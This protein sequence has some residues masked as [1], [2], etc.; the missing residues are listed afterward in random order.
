MARWGRRSVLAALAGL[1]A[2]ALGAAGAASGN[3]IGSGA[4][5]SLP[6]PPPLKPGSRVVA[7]APG[8][9]WEQPREELA[10]LG[11]RV[12]GAGWELVVPPATGRRWQWFS[13]TDHQRR[14]AL[15][16]AI[17]GQRAEA[18]LAVTAGWGSARLLE[19]GW[20]EPARPVWLVGFSDASALLLAQCASGRGGAI[21]GGLHGDDAQWSRL[22]RLL[23]G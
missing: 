21:H 12:Q 18:L 9:W 22:V 1:A 7:I 3:R 23:R 11:P 15:E 8:T 2:P 5:G 10:L 17:Q 4:A 20:Q 14:T 13:G 19:S 6:M 16:E